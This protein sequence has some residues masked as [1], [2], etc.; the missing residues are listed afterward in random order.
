M[1]TYFINA[2]VDDDIFSYW[3]AYTDTNIKTE[4]RN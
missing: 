3:T 2:E 4:F 1:R